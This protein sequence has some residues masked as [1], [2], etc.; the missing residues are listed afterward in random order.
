MCLTM[1]V[2]R[3]TKECR[4]AGKG[5]APRFRASVPSPSRALRSLSSPP[6]VVICVVVLGLNANLASEARLDWFDGESSLF[7]SRLW[8]VSRS[9]V[10]FSSRGRCKW[11]NMRELMRLSDAGGGYM[12]ERRDKKREGYGRA[13]DS[14][15]LIGCARSKVSERA[16]DERFKLT[17]DAERTLRPTAET[18]AWD[19]PF[20]AG[21][22]GRE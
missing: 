8:T 20:A 22:V 14:E 18:K 15:G 21:V 11:W 19:P 6:N 16:S 3:F 17:V 4:A 9:R 13:G 2:R 12:R 7:C 10:S 5:S 1:L